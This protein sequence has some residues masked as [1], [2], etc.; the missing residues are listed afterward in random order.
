MRA[1]FRSAVVLSAVLMSTALF[2]CA[3]A[4]QSETADPS[5]VEQSL[6]TDDRSR[7]DYKGRVDRTVMESRAPGA[8]HHNVR[9]VFRV[10]GLGEEQRKIIVCREM[11]TNLDGIKDVV[12]RYDDEGT[13][14]SEEADANYDG[15]MDTW[16]TFALGKVA[17][18]ELDTSGDGKP[19]ESRLYVRGDLSRVQRDT[20]A[21]GRPDVWEIYSGEKLERL[22]VDLDHDGRVDR[23]DRDA[24]AVARPLPQKPAET[25][26]QASESPGA[27]GA[28]PSQPVDGAAAPNGG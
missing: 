22:G 8:A 10:V 24:A 12:R 13:P 11:D 19:D 18:L 3:C 25:P 17:S 6:P 27:N 5:E 9:R 1:V 28:A 15:N 4:E 23:W 14:K 16:I 26:S 21:D 2:L 7:C 20:N